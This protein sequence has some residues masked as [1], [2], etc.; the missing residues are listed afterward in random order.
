MRD[1]GGG[2]GLTMSEVVSSQNGGN[3][4]WGGRGNGGCGEF[5]KALNV[6]LFLSVFKF[7]P[8]NVMSRSSVF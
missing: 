5:G 3:G 1:E 8:F 7:S 2:H 4:V 6:I